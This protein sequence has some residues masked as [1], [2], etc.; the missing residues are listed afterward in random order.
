ME[1]N[2]LISEPGGKQKEDPIVSLINNTDV[3]NSGSTCPS[4]YYFGLEM[5]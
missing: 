2:D 3:S 4:A 1:N 5:I